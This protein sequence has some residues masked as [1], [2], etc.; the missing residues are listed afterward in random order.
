M[1][2]PPRCAR[3]P[4]VLRSIQAWNLGYPGPMSRAFVLLTLLVVGGLLAAFFNHPLAYGAWTV[5]VIADILYIAKVG[6]ARIARD[7]VAGEQRARAAQEAEKARAP[8]PEQPQE[9]HQGPPAALVVERVIERQVLVT[10]CRFC[11][12]LTPVDLADCKSCG[13]RL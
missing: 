11:N 8:G 4:V 3:R 6:R 12:E 13:A 9:P 10:R 7:R 1:R 2:Y 5:A